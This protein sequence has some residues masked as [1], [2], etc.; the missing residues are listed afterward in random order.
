[1]RN[2]RLFL[3]FTVFTVVAVFGGLYV[4]ERLALSPPGN[5]E[6]QQTAE[7]VAREIVT[8][9]FTLVAG[10]GNVVTD[11]DFRGEWLLVFFGFTHCPDICPTTL[12]TMALILDELGED[13]RNLQPLFITVDPARDTP[14]VLAAYV[15]A[16]H[17]KIIGLTGSEEQVADAAKSHAAYYARIPLSEGTAASDDYIMDHTAHL[18]L[19]DPDG[20]YATV[21]SPTHTIESIVSDIRERMAR[22]N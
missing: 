17:P 11:T 3:W 18:Y 2:L 15:A 20:V 13:G 22:R 5:T 4:S 14:D 19:M 8:G 6:Q 1:M 9:E 16:F 7:Q 12:G 21:Y 10:D